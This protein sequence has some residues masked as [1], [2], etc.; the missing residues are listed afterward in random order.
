MVALGCAPS[1]SRAHLLYGEWLRRK[2][3]RLDG[4]DQLVIAGR[5]FAEFGMEAFAEH[6]RVERRQVYKPGRRDPR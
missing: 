4:G 1:S 5:L 6:A 3:R 2:R